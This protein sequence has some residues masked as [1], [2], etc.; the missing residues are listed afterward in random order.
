M[1]ARPEIDPPK[2]GVIGCSEG[3]LVGAI[4]ATRSAD[5][6]FV[7][8]PGGVGVPAQE[9][10]RARTLDHARKNQY[11]PN[12][13]A[14]QVEV[15]ESFFAIVTD[16]EDREA[17]ATQLEHLLER[18]AGGLFDETYAML[19]ED[20]EA[21][22]YLLSSPWYRSQF[23]FDPGRVLE[24]LRVPV[25]AVTGDL[26]RVDPAEQN[27]PAILAALERGRNPDYTITRAPG[28]NHIFQRA[29]EGGPKEYLTLDE[30]FSPMAAEI[31]SSWIRIRF[32]E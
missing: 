15:M 10:F 13:V 32:G 2:I 18:D 27:L 19:P 31:V 8:M 9:L 3:A 17:V 30:D 21:R 24:Q 20:A 22:I 12:R 7:V 11:A 1:R 26:D 4:A 14:E 29:E 6:A 25:L 5:V 16:E 28:L 23:S